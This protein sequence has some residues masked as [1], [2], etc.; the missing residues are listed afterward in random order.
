VIIEQAKGVLAEHH[1]ITVD[2]GFALLCAHSRNHNRSL[3]DVARDVAVR[4][5]AAAE[6]LPRQPAPANLT[7]ATRP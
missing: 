1:R 4:A 2:E 5:L 6:L 3:S 7:G